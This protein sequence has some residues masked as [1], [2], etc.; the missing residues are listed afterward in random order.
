[1]AELAAAQSRTEAQLGALTVVVQTLVV[2][3]ERTNARLDATLGWTFE[4][5]FRDRLTSFLG[6]MMRRGRLLRNDEVLDAIESAIDAGEA[7]EVL[8]ADAIAKG[9]IDGAASHVVVEVSATCA[10]D[11]VDRA[12]RRAGILRKAGLVAVPLV[13]CEAISREMV[14]YARSRQVRVWC[15]GTMLDEAA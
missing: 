15:N 14:A 1:M 9:I 3:A 13:A 11:D 5:R 2:Q 12:E 7:D 8:R 10:A 6:R 4:L